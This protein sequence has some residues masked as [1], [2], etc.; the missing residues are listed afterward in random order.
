MLLPVNG[1]IWFSTEATAAAEN[2]YMEPD[3]F[4]DYLTAKVRITKAMVLGE[5]TFA[6][7]LGNF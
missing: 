3:L 1:D 6:L 5:E 7:I 4:R 2:T